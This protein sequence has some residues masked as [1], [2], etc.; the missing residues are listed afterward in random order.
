MKFGKIENVI[1]F[2]GGPFL[3]YACDQIKKYGL[4]VAAFT[5]KRHLEEKIH[6]KPMI[7][8][9]EEKEVEYYSSDNINTDDT[10]EAFINNN[11]I[12][13]SIGSAWIFKSSFID[14]FQGRLLNMH[15]TLLPKNKGGGGFSWQILM[16]NRQGCC[17]LHKVDVGIDTGDIVKYKEFY[18]PE[19]CKIPQDYNDKYFKQNKLF[20]D[21]FLQ[22]I[23]NNI[24]FN[25][26]GQSEYHS[27]YWPRLNTDLH[28]YIDWSYKSENIYRFIN[29]FDDPY[30][31]A[32][33]FIDDIKVR[34]KS[35]FHDFNDGLFHPFQTG[36]I[37]RKSDTAIFVA[38]ESGTLI[39]QKVLD[40]EGKNIIGE[41]KLGSRFYTPYKYLENAKMSRVIYT[42]KGVK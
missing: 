35:C 34:I 42:P 15:G 2:G 4:K 1:L 10:I 30:A 3:I 19:S 6:D 31:G 29:A 9:L 14:K 8:W 7:Q 39:V 11:T 26:S 28:G 22:E 20:F 36:I 17:L 23:E 32:I 16:A 37:F 25:I 12:G 40:Y 27:T 38:A 33:T 41:M 24:D 13:I 5:A 21:E 18:Y